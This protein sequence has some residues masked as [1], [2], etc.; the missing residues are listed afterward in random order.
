MS[1][2]D[3]RIVFRPTKAHANADGLS[4][5]PVPYSSNEP[6]LPDPK[7]FNIQQI[8]TLPLMAAQLK[9]ATARDPELS[10]VLMYT[11]TGWPLKVPPVLLPYWNRREELSVENDCVLWGIRVIIPRKFRTTVLQEIHH[12]HMGIVRMKIIARSYV[13]WPRIDA[14]I[15]QMVKSCIPC[16]ENRNAPPV[17]PMHSWIWPMKPWQ[18]LH[19]DFAGPIGGKSYLII[20]DA[21]SKW[22]E[23]VGMKSTTAGATIKA[24]RRLFAAYGLPNQLVSNN[25]P[26]FTSTEFAYFL[27][28]NGIKHIKCVP[29]HPS[30]NGCAERFVQT[31]KRALRA[32]DYRGL[33]A[34]QRLMAFLLTYRS[35]PHSTTGVPPC[36]LFLN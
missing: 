16:Q 21:H 4:R 31:F 22:P 23:V 13:W 2:Y 25:G 24:L 35:S 33:T 8:E 34:E 14:D 9:T 15:E 18:R 1:S 26:Q 30:S 7:L 6:Y 17:A 11:K 36:K 29:Y 5:L 32:D 10:K 19:V 20:V 27:K 3:Y 12:T 28:A